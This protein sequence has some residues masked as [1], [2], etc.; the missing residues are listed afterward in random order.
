MFVCLSG[1][2]SEQ[3][4]PNFYQTRTHLLLDTRES[5]P[6]ARSLSGVDSP[7][8]NMVQIPQPK[9][10]KSDHQKQE[11]NSRR[12]IWIL[13]GNDQR[14]NAKIFSGSTTIFDSHL[15]VLRGPDFQKW[16]STCFLKSKNTL[17]CFKLETQSQ[18]SQE[19]CTITHV[20]VQN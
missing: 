1:S 18:S 9:Q 12:T 5:T 2:L 7:V 17:K 19:Y 4:E 3:S 8:S 16:V 14:V 10:S 15:R 13:S 20:Q 11:L 6:Q